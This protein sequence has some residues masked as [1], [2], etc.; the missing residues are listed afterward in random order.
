MH[1]HT[2]SHPS[3]FGL[4]WSPA[5][6]ALAI[7]LTLLFL[8]FLFLCMTLTAPPAFAQAQNSVPATAREAASMPQFAAR[9]APQAQR[10]A[11]ASQAPHPVPPRASSINPRNPRTRGQRGWLPDDNTLYDNGPI[12]GNTDA[13]TINFGFAVSDTFTTN[14]SQITGLQ[15]GAWLFPGDVLLSAEV[16]IGTA[17]YGNDLFDQT[18]SFTQSSNCPINT[19]GYAICTETA[20][21]TANIAAGTY[22]I[23][24]QNAVVNTGD[25]LYWDEN[26]GPSLASENSVGTIPS[27]AFTI[28]GS[29]TTTCNDCGPPPP[30]PCFH[31]GIIHD[32]TADQYGPSGV[33]LDS[34]GNVYGAIASGGD[35]GFGMVY[36]LS[37]VVENWIS[38]TLYSFTGDANGQ[39]P[40]GVVVGPD[41][42]LYGT[43]GGGIQNCNGPCGLV[44]KLRPPPNAC[45]AALCSWTETVLYRFTGSPDG[46]HPNGNLV[47]DQAGNLYGTTVFGG[48]YG[49]HGYGGTVFE[50]T[51]SNGGWTEKII[52]SFGGPGDS[53][54]PNS[55]LMGPDGNLYG[56]TQ[57][58]GDPNCTY[59]LNSCGVVFQLAPSGD[60][61]T[62]LVLHTF[63]NS[64]DDG[65]K[66][67][68]LVQDGSGNLYGI[69]NWAGYYEYPATGGVEFMLSPSNGSWTFN[70]LI[71][72]YYPA[73]ETYFTGLAT[74][75]Q[76]HTS[77]AGSTVYENRDDCGYLDLWCD[78]YILGQHGVDYYDK[79]FHPY[80]LATDP[81]G[82]RLYG[83]TADCGANGKG[84][85]WM[86]GP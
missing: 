32:F 48:A 37:Q 36:R 27:E 28:L 49:P 46:D 20:T 15:F 6:T 69:S 77:V 83:V 51:P 85:V 24:L 84:T 43:A 86:S 75:A 10:H 29:T 26:S 40:D 25:P 52:H 82:K 78:W 23:T 19:F 81:G 68:N 44:Y 57:V 55:L 66:P 60:G 58:G 39:T 38:T 47:F 18:V 65:A 71:L 41:R 70:E 17:E 8:I 64:P 16:L 33:T 80:G 31:S 76:G 22:W 74:D 35:N 5:N 13:W 7:L 3:I 42:A 54:I 2:H 72:R 73:K 14:G 67:Q 59:P 21:F 1:S 79:T 34:A 4:N 56:T 9:L 45:P 30:P 61:W 62:E 50:L 12:N 63:E 53:W 11:M